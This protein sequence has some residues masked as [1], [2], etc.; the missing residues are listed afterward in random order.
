[1]AADLGD[2][3]RRVHSAVAVAQQSGDEDGLDTVLGGEANRSCVVGE[4]L[5][6]AFLVEVRSAHVLLAG[7]VGRPVGAVVPRPP[8]WFVKFHDLSPWRSYTFHLS[9]T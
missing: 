6:G 9:G 8:D 5:L 2:F 4:E 1:V 3:A 7:R